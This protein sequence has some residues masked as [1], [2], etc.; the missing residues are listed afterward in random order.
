[1]AKSILVVDDDPM[2]LKV[3]EFIL[4]QNSYE[5][6]LA[7]SGAEALEVIKGRRVDLVLLDI[8]MPVMN[9]IE[10]FEN[11]V[12][13]YIEIPV[14]FLTASENPQDEMEATGLGA[15]DYVKKPFN[16]L[17]LLERVSKVF[18]NKEQSEKNASDGRI[19][20]GDG[21]KIPIGEVKMFEV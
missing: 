3:A 19:T 16:P 6:I 11:I 4:K 2:N 14:M 9:G 7:N 5:V 13:E 20:S 10:T 18:E 8:E 17:D 1:M 21:K 12:L 15:A